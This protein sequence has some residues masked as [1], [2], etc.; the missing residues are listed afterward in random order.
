MGAEGWSQ[1]K[2]GQG[3]LRGCPFPWAR[4]LSG[5]PLP[6][7]AISYTTNLT[8]IPSHVPI[9]TPRRGAGVREEQLPAPQ[10]RQRHGL[11]R[12]G[13][14]LPMLLHNCCCVATARRVIIA[15]TMAASCHCERRALA[16]TTRQ[17]SWGT[18][19]AAEERQAGRWTC[20]TG[21]R[22]LQWRRAMDEHGPPSSAVSRSS[23]HTQ[24]A[25]SLLPGGSTHPY[26]AALACANLPPRAAYFNTLGSPSG[27]ARWYRQRGGRPTRRAGA[28]RP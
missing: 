4:S 23:K 3:T 18:K 25:V 27:Q 24:A 19:Q 20:R 17:G 28:A 6:T 7:A 1:A 22:R 2:A 11:W 9:T 21:A 13:L 8:P 26:C 5:R 16:A 14:M 12:R 10:R 15:V